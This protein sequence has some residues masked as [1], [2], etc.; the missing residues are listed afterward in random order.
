MLGGTWRQS[1]GVRWFLFGWPCGHHYLDRIH[2]FFQAF[3]LLAD[4]CG[5]LGINFLMCR[6]SS[7]WFNH[8][9]PIVPHETQV[10]SAQHVE[11]F[12]FFRSGYVSVLYPDDV[13]QRVMQRGKDAR[14]QKAKKPA[15]AGV[16]LDFRAV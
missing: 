6:S 11:M 9:S 15:F 5:P 4:D 13:T 7:C 10:A 2:F 1:T 3:N 12:K 8:P 14:G 16:L